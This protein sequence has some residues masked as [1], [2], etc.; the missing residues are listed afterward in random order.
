MS[1]FTTS[2]SPMITNQPATLTYTNPSVNP[3]PANQYV[4]KDASGANVS[5]TIN[6]TSNNINFSNN[7]GLPSEWASFNS[8]SLVHPNGN[9]YTT[10]KNS[11]I[12]NNGCIQVTDPSGVSSLYLQFNVIL[13]KLNFSL[14]FQPF[15]HENHYHAWI[16]IFLKIQKERNCPID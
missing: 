8:Y 12:A 16:F 6:P 13:N 5:N 3:I 2:P 1:S 15:Y 10:M 11:S 7:I 9:V 4:L 14:N